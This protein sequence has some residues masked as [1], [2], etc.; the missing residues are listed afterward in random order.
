M[1]Y[2]YGPV[3]S[4]RLGRS[5]GVDLISGEKNCTFECNYCQLGPTVRHIIKRGLFVPTAA[6]IS[7]LDSLPEIA[8]DYITLSGTGEPTLAVNLGEVI[9]AIKQRFKQ[10]VAVL[11]NSSLM[12]QPEVRKELSLTDLVVA[13]LDA[14][15][16]RLFQEINHPT[17]G[18]TLRLVLN[19]IK[20]FQ[21]EYPGRLALQIMIV[22][23]NKE[24][25]ADLARLAKQIDPVEVQLNTPL[26]PCPVEPLSKKELEP[27]KELFA[28]LKVYTVYDVERPDARPIDEAETK[29]RRPVI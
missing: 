17:N 6:I 20:Q 7:E 9:A 19:G 21:E 14:P 10:P 27:L 4:W 26:R 25:V 15:D 29:K 23:Q 16:E 12:H 8:I 3:P 13:K 28:P 2:I 1:K 5:L 24:R 11:T 18:T 22:P